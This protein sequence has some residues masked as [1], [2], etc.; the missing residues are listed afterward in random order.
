MKKLFT[1][2]LVLLILCQSVAAQSTPEKIE[3]V[4]KSYADQQLFNGAVL[5]A[6]KGKVIYKGG[7]GLANMEWN[8]PNATNTKFRVGSVSKQFTSMLIM[9]L[10]Q[11]GK[12]KLNEPIISYLPQYRKETGKKVTVHHLLTHSSGIP[13]YTNDPNFFQ[14]VSRT[15]YSVPDFVRIHCS[16]NL[17]FEP[18][19]KFNY[20]NSGYFILGAILEAVSKQPYDKLL[21]QKILDPLGMKN[22]GYDHSETIIPNRASGYES[23]LDGYKN[24]GFL[25]MALPYSAGSL[26]STVEDLLI[27]DRAL[28][29]ETL[30]PDSLKKIMFSPHIEAG[31]PPGEEKAYAAYGWFIQQKKTADPQKKILTIS[32]SGGING[33]GA[34]IIRYPESERVFIAMDNTS[35]YNQEK[36]TG[37]IYSILAGESYQIPKPSLSHAILKKI[38][39]AGPTAAFDFYKSLT[40]QQ[41]SGYDLVGAEQKINR[42]GY[43]LLN[44]KNDAAGAAKIFEINVREFPQSSNVYDSY[45]EALMKLGNY[46]LAIENYKKAVALDST[47]RRALGMIAQMQS[48]QASEKTIT[49]RVDGHDMNLFLTGDKGPVIVLEA[50]GGST[51]DCWHPIVSELA[52]FARVVTYDRPGFGGSVSC[53]QPRTAARVA[54]ELKEAL[55]KAGIKGPYI[56]AGWSWGGAFARVF[57]GKYPAETRGVLLLDPSMRNTYQRMAKEQPDAYTL[58]LQERPHFHH[59][60]RNEFEAMDPTML[61]AD[62]SDKTYKGKIIVFIAGSYKEWEKTQYPL[63]KIWNEEL[64]GWA[65]KRPNT[66][67]ET[68][69]SGHAIQFEK[70]ER[71]IKALK[72]LAASTATSAS[73]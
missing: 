2:S 59:A 54:E 47:N 58:T 50:G 49:V 27:W 68:I 48:A 35:Q 34:Y 56:M 3:Q 64:E 31:G 40:A 41:K 55:T 20:S 22:T 24:T 28:Y 71:V 14:F 60:T 61:Q 16:G 25:D 37:Y 17:E 51:H 67:V 39:A 11:E 23:G 73:F 65:R 43:G 8:I 72:E 10:V 26:Y 32:H 63:K 44:D 53:T 38:Q 62:E 70:P 52:K 57:A 45:G 30:L 9:Q 33:F 21:Q 1:A 19:S 29:T 5:V 7:F 4:I 12:I 66:R 69:D 13:N 15:H 18:G 36:M 6:E 42:F 46:P